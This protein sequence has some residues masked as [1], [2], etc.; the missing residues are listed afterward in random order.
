MVGSKVKFN[1]PWGTEIQPKTAVGATFPSEVLAR[2]ESFKIAG[3]NS[4]GTNFGR[5]R[6]ESSSRK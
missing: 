5:S 2:S 4:P 6:G 3:G 1:G